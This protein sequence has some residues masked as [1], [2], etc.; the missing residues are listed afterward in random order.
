M[1][2][3]VVQTTGG[4]RAF[5]V[6]RKHLANPALCGQRKIREDDLQ[7]T[8]ITMLNKLAYSRDVLLLLYINAVTAEDDKQ[9]EQRL[10]NIQARLKVIRT[11]R[12]D[13]VR[14]YSRGSLEAAEYFEKNIVCRREE[15]ELLREKGIA[16]R[17]FGHTSSAK[18]LDD[19]VY[20]WKIGTSC[21][22][23]SSFRALTDH[24]LVTNQSQVT[25][26][27]KCGLRLSE[28]IGVRKRPGSVR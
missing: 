26:V 1:K 6:C 19:F 13:L 17:F 23:Q 18:A 12:A 10:H 16:E 4:R 24:I 9:M 25:F 14:L 5:W 2:R 8:Y 20:D 3:Q 22:P 27:M 28:D 15:R 21:F 7:N 11:N